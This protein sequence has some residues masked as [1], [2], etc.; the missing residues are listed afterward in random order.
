MRNL[1]SLGNQLPRLHF[2][3]NVLLIYNRLFCLG[4]DSNVHFI[5]QDDAVD[6]NL[7]MNLSQPFSQGRAFAISLLEALVSTVRQID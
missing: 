5:D 3:A 6:K 1:L 2:N 4:Y 7:T